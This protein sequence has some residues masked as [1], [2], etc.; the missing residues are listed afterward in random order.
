MNKLSYEEAY[1]KITQLGCIPYFKKDEWIGS[2]KDKKLI[3]YWFI[4]KC[5]HK[6]Y[7][8][9]SCVVN[10]KQ[11][12]CNLCAL[13]NQKK[14]QRMSIE[15]FNKYAEIF[16]EK[17][18]KILSSYKDYKNFKQ[19]LK[20]KCTICNIIFDLSL[21]NGLKKDSHGCINIPKGEQIVL[22]TLEINGIDY[23]YQKYIM[24]LNLTSD[25]EIMLKNNNLIHIEIDGDQHYNY[26]NQF[27]KTYE[28]F[29]KAKDRDFEKDKWYEER[30]YRNI[31]IRYN[32]GGKNNEDINKI[33]YE[34]IN[35]KYGECNLKVK[36]NNFNILEFNESYRNK[37]IIAYDLNGDLYKIFNSG[38]EAEKELGINNGTISECLYGKRN[39]KR[40]GKYI[41]TI[42]TENYP[43]KIDKYYYSNTKPILMYKDGVL[44]GEYSAGVN[45]IERIYKIPKSSLSRYLNGKGNNPGK[46]YGYDFKYKI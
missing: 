40:A 32:V 27:H 6:F 37:K 10:R 26:P 23:N 45:E 21:T 19:T 35:G 13:E 8:D 24:E 9:Y 46:K 33:I 36:N 16:M 31:H 11:V 14:S 7:R 25:F 41:F 15:E 29:L 20:C 1:E 38:I 44:K 22:S 30:G 2:R 5:G 34:I 42:Y 4:G 43:I 12:Y 18:I 17:D 28:D 3:K 39:V